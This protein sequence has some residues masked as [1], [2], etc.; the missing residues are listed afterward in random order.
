MIAFIQWGVTPLVDNRPDNDYFYKISVY[1][2]LRQNAGTKSKVCFILSG[3]H[4]DTGVRVMDDGRGKVRTTV[5]PDSVIQGK[6]NK[7]TLCYLL[8]LLPPSF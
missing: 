2:G 8:S 4:G 6:N 3:D 5:I 7:H 1:T